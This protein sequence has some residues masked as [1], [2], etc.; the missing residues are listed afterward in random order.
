MDSVWQDLAH[1]VRALTRSPSF[2]IAV[3]LTFALGI[4]TTAAIFTVVEAVLLQSPPYPEADRIVALGLGDGRSQD[5]QDGQTF[6]YVRAHTHVFEWVAAHA[7]SSGWNLVVH[8]RAAYVTGMPVSE[9]FFAVLGVPPLLGRPFSAA[10]DQANGPQAVVLSAA[11]WHREFASRP[12]TIG[13]TVELGGIPHVIVGVMPDGFQ[14]IPKVDLWTPLRASATDRSLNYTV[15]ARLRP[16]SS[17]ARA[18]G[19]LSSFTPRM[20]HELPSLSAS[21]AQLLRWIPYRLWIGLQDRDTVLLLVAAVA[22]LLLL[23]CVNVASLQLVRA[24]TR[25]RE[26]AM[27]AALGASRRRIVQHVVIE[28][29]V[30]AVGG[31]AIGVLLAHWSLN[32]FLGWLPPAL[33]DDRAIRIDRFVLAIIVAVA[34]LSGMSVG[35]APALATA[36]VDV[37]ATLA[38]GAHAT[39]GRAALWMR[40]LLVVVEVALAV[41]M[42]VSAGLL[43]RTFVRLRAVPLGF[44]PEHIVVGKMTLQ[45]SSYQTAD[46]IAEFF[47]R[48]LTRIRDVSGVDAA[49]VGSNIPVERGLNLPVEPPPGA[50]VE[51]MTAVD[52][53]YVTPEFFIVFET[54][55]HLGRGFTA[56]DQPRTPPVAVV[57]EAFVRTYFGSANPLGRTI[58]LARTLGDPPRT[59]VGVVGDVKGR[60]GAGWTHGP[61]A[62]GA[63]AAPTMYVPAAQVP[64]NISRVVH[65]FFPINWVVRTR[66]PVTAISAQVEALVHG[67]DPRLPF[68]RFEPMTEIVARDIETQR[69]LLLLL[70]AFAVASLTLAALGIYGVI[71][72]TAVERTQEIGIRM[73]LGARAVT[74]VRAFI[75]EGLAVA[76]IGIV[77]GV[78]LAA[79]STRMLGSVLSGVAPLDPLTFVVGIG[80]LLVA[81]ALATLIPATRASRVDPLTALRHE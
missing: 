77:I 81:A 4:G 1:A 23:A 9:D 29:V 68:I 75:G 76:A 11:L 57:N 51:R 25:R 36:H 44:D 21:R 42:L 7:G 67:T 6:H 43:L 27:R 17:V 71:S 46:Q 18:A 12:D 26:M 16:G 65:Q 74:I 39:S 60:S 41:L 52:W 54:P 2:A 34:M 69:F 79:G 63:P 45:G 48:S 80:V 19:E 70:G 28:S 22:C 38:E 72:Y 56:L 5:S 58:Q 66:L 13:S 61:N 55:V 47:E 35:I 62:L 33:V 50:D 64:E 78:A 10:E 40:K 8:D 15:L 59:I 20:P 14:T 53:R 73:A 49:A 3:L 32:G 24:V 31:A 30:L 37:R